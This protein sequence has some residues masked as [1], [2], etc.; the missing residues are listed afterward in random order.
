MSHTKWKWKFC[1]SAN[2]ADVNAPPSEQSA[3]R[4][5][6]GTGNWT[7][8][9]PTK[10][11]TSCES[12]IPHLLRLRPLPLLLPQHQPQLP[13]PHPP[14]LQNPAYSHPY[15][16]ANAHPDT[17]SRVHSTST[18]QPQVPT[19][20][21]EPLSSNTPSPQ[22]FLF[23][24]TP[25]QFSSR[26]S[27]YWWNCLYRLCRPYNQRVCPSAAGLST[28]CPLWPGPFLFFLSL[29]NPPLLPAKFIGRTSSSKKPPTFSSTPSYPY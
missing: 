29:L 4:V 3:A 17:S 10:S 26:R 28:G 5:P 27:Y 22:F 23:R 18:V 12:L 25:H 14:L 20:S 1:G 16:P 15:A 24:R 13:H 11:D 21:V 9:S 2:S 6:D 7:I 19:S 8:G